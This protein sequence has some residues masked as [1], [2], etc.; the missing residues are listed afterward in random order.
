MHVHV[1]MY[2]YMYITCHS[3]LFYKVFL[4]S[5]KIMLCL[6]LPSPTENLLL[7]NNSILW[8]H[9]TYHTKRNTHKT[10]IILDIEK[11]YIHVVTTY[12]YMYMYIHLLHSITQ[13]L[14]LVDCKTKVYL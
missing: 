8:H 10:V 2:M 13:E 14:L 11:L 4:M 6:N 1:Y 12:I 3:N 9:C 7:T 5:I